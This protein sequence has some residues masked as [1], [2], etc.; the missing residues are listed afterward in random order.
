MGV[1]AVFGSDNPE[2]LGGAISEA[3]TEGD[4][5]RL[6]SDDW[7]IAY[8]GTLQELCRKIGISPPLDHPEDANWFSDV[9]SAIAVSVDRYWGYHKAETWDWLASKQDK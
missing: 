5:Y 9:G 4:Y 3:I 2:D 6:P 7:L 8:D 1:Y